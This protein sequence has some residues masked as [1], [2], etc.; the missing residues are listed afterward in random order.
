MVAVETY[1]GLIDMAKRPGYYPNA[2]LELAWFGLGDSLR[3]QKKFG[4][5]VAA[6]REGANQ[7]TI[8]PEL[9]RRC[10]LEA[11]KTFDL[12]REHDKAVQQYEAVLNA[13][14]DTVQGEQARKYMKSAYTGK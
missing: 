3:G 8:S 7:A 14:S 13:G 9:K 6:Y 2:H 4:D 12:M 10:L 11:G 5:A 1:E